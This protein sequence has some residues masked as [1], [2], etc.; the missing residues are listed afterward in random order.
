[1]PTIAKVID[2]RAREWVK[3]LTPLYHGVEINTLVLGQLGTT[4][5]KKITRSGKNGIR[6]GSFLAPL[7]GKR[8]T[9]YGLWRCGLNLVAN[10]MS[11]KKGEIPY[12]IEALKLPLEE[13]VL[14]KI[15]RVA[16]GPIQPGGWRIWNIT[17][18]LADSPLAGMEFLIN[19]P[20]HAAVR[21]FGTVVSKI[22]KEIRDYPEYLTGCWARVM[23]ASKARKYYIQQAW[24][25][26]TSVNKSVKAYRESCKLYPCHK[27]KHG[28]DTCKFAV[29]TIGE[30]EQ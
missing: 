11:I 12:S 30:K 26:Y 19:M 14:V 27:C 29:K 6:L 8:V 10:E 9:A 18:L 17:L 22:P 16:P 2:V 1:M 3:V 7:L 4:A 20:E 21:L 15:V 28:L 23:M 25:G 13:K 5:A 24:P